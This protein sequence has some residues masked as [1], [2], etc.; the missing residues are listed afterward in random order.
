MPSWTSDE[1]YLVSKFFCSIDGE[2]AE[3]HVHKILFGCYFFLSDKMM[4]HKREAQN[5]LEVLS[6]FGGLVPVVFYTFSFVG[7]YVN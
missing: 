6:D 1:G 7:S 2:Q 5:I 3:D 4:T